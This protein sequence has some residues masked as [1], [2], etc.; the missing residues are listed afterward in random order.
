MMR[1]EFTAF[2]EEFLPILEPSL[3]IQRNLIS[4]QLAEQTPEVIAAREIVQSEFFEVLYKMAVMMSEEKKDSAFQI[5]LRIYLV[6]TVK[7]LKGKV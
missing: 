6:E 4:L 7:N 5:G 2:M 3:S 1:P